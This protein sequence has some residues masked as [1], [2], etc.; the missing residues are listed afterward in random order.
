[1]GGPA[2][3]D[4]RTHGGQDEAAQE[5]GAGEGLAVRKC[6]LKRAT[7]RDNAPSNVQTRDIRLGMRC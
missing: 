1:M 4:T 7:P 6:T 5:I 3:L 2:F